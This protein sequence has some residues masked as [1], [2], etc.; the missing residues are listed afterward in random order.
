MKIN[1][2]ALKLLFWNYSISCSSSCSSFYLLNTF[3]VK[4]CF[5]SF[6]AVDIEALV[7]DTYFDLVIPPSKFSIPIS[8]TLFKTLICLAFNSLS[9]W[10]SQNLVLSIIYWTPSFASSSNFNRVFKK[11][12]NHSVISSGSSFFLNPMVFSRTS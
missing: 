1:M 12:S 8:R 9:L 7:M 4:N 6:E 5:K 2:N 10:I 11:Y 3:Q